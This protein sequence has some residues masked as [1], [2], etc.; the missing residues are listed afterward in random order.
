M[1]NIHPQKT[2]LY[3][4][5]CNFLG[6]RLKSFLY[7]LKRK[8]KWNSALYSPSSK[9]KKNPPWD[10]FLLSNIKKFLLFSKK[11]LFLY[12]RKWK[13][14]KKIFYFT[15]RNFLIF[16]D[17]KTLKNFLNFRK[18][19]PCWKKSKKPLWKNFRKR[20]KYLVL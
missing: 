11:T 19:I 2:S 4:R 9:N 3:F 6:L 18:Y 12:F 16:Q 1:K 15:K 5:K 13:P 20:K 17:I 8:R 14:R 10:K 7:F